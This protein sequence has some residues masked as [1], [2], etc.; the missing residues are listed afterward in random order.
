MI[1]FSDSIIQLV[2][3]I[4]VLPSTILNVIALFLPNTKLVSICYGL[5]FPILAAIIVLITAMYV[6]NVLVL[7]N[8]YEQVISTPQVNLLCMYIA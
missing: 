4:L 6:G 7:Y 1:K 8:A 3:F 5:Q 2:M